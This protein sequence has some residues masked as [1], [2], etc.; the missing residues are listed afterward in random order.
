MIQSVVVY[1]TTGFVLV[2]L[3]RYYVKFPH[4][5]HNYLLWALIFYSIVFGLRYGVGADYFG[6][7]EIY[8]YY[9]QF[10]KPLTDSLEP[11]FLFLMKLFPFDYQLFLGII[12]FLQI[13]FLFKGFR[14]EPAV[15]P[16]VAYTFMV[17][18][19]W[20]TFA[21]ALRQ[22]LAFSLFIASLP[23]IQN[24]NWLA[25]YVV[26]LFAILVHTSAF[27]LLLF[28]PVFCYKNEWFRNIKVQLLLVIISL[29]L[30]KAE[31]SLGVIQLIDVYIQM[32]LY[33]DYLDMSSERSLA[34]LSSEV[35]LG[36]GFF[37]S[38]LIIVIQICYSNRVKDYFKNSMVTI[39]YN[40]FFIGVLWKHLFVSS[41]IF[42]RVNYYLWGT[43]FIIGAYTLVYLH[44][45]SQKQLFMLLLGLYFLLFVGTISNYNYDLVRYYF[46]WE[47]NNFIMPETFR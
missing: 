8:T 29:I 27:L 42:Q 47:K 18:C 16:Y 43:S 11:G 7:Q 45:S 1:L 20:L 9:Q 37:V 2:Q 34:K 38:L 5:E 46:F 6:Y 26:V 24:K 33:A 14:N 15:I 31:L 25:Y 13:L 10:K 35:S 41:Q 40:L 3:S 21:N 23:Y 39:V 22:E 36:I 44:K 30:L 12:A 32:T 17:S 4:R 19:T 28:Y